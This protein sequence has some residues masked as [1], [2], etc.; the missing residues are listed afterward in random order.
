METTSDIF[1]QIVKNLEKVSSTN[2]NVYLAGE[3][4]TGKSRFAKWI[5][6]QSPRK[7]RPF[8]SVNC[9]ALPESLIESELF[10]YEKGAFT[11][12]LQT[13]IGKFEAA[14]TGTI[15]LDEIGT[16][17]LSAQVTLLSI[18]QDRVITR[19]GGNTE[20]PID[21]RIIS[22]SNE[23]LNTLCE[24]QLF[25]KDLFF[26]LNVFPVTLPPLRER[27]RDIPQLIDE[28][29][30]H[31]APRYNSPVTTISADALQQLCNYEWPG[32]IRELENIIERAIILCSSSTI[33]IE[34]LPAD[35][36]HA[37]VVKIPDPST[38]KMT[39]KDT[40]NVAIDQAERSYLNAALTQHK[41]KINKT[42][43]YAGITTRQLHKLMKK[44]TLEKNKFH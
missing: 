16:M 37:I 33:E 38:T 43:H 40:R 27:H 36:T 30:Q 17:P 5:H 44:H 24:K 18:I 15:F 8:V 39:L 14:H 6:E 42:A 28:T 3:T 35:I 4:G 1:T 41:G 25:R 13:K 23:D 11:G 29:I 20:H 32:N 21:I 31:L 7:H 34:H 22:A 12:A 26:R 9:G 2:A 19:I 10:G